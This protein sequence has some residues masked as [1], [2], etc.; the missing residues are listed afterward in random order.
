M[1]GEPHVA[2]GSGRPGASRRRRAAPAPARAAPAVP[3]G[4]HVGDVVVV[5]VGPRAGACGTVLAVDDH[6]EGNQR[7]VHV[8][9]PQWLPLTLKDTERGGGHC[10]I[11][12]V[13]LTLVR[14]ARGP[15]R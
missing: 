14:R 12:R 5:R 13:E 8:A 7:M 9:F 3:A 2:G 15:G 10:W 4:F 6:P 11:D 1:A